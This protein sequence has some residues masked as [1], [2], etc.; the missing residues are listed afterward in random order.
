MHRFAK[1]RA[2]SWRFERR[3]IILE[4]ALM[5]LAALQ[6]LSEATGIRAGL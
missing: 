1:A 2:G 6:A 4:C 3:R 5:A